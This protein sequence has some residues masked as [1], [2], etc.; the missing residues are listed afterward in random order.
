[1]CLAHIYVHVSL[2]FVFIYIYFL[3]REQGGEKMMGC[4]LHVI[5][6]AAVVGTTVTSYGA[7]VVA[8]LSYLQNHS[9]DVGSLFR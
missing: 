1:M 9:K 2:F 8:C 5:T 4:E 6:A 3:V 7:L